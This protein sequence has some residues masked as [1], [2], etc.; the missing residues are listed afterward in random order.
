M[1]K[2]LVLLAIFALPVVNANAADM[3]IKAPP[4]PLTSFSWTGLYVGAEMG[5][6]DSHTDSV[7]NVANASFPV[8]F[9]DTI[10]TTGFLGGLEA[11]ANYQ[12]EWLVVGVEGDW[13]GSSISGTT[14]TF[15]PL[16]PGRYTAESRE[17]D[18]VSTVTGRL[19]LA[20]GRWM[21]FGKGGEAWR[22][23]NDSAS[24]LTY[25]GAGALL[26]DQT[27]NPS[28]QAGYVVGGGVEWAPY[29]QLSFKLEY[30]GYNFG[31]SQSTGGVCI[32]GGCGGAGAIVGPGETTNTPRM[33]EI[34]G[35]VNFR[36]NWP[37]GPMAARF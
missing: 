15:S 37:M 3:P 17:T 7:R 28:T 2:A 14:K 20:W 33:W 16:V 4:A 35:G 6:G 11:G 5:A 18:W 29:D 13:Q 8:G 34:K 23:V 27:V 32:T 24:N 25:S 19:G 10:N 1:R 22:R 9:A 30:D 31:T 26:S 12:F 36:F 21:L